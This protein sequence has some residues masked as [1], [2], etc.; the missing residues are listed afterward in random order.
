MDTFSFLLLILENLRLKLFAGFDYGIVLFTKGLARHQD[1]DNSWTPQTT[2]LR[3]GRKA[4]EVILPPRPVRHI[5]S[6]LILLVLPGRFFPTQWCW[7]NLCIPLL[8][9]PTSH[10]SRCWN[11]PTYLLNIANL[12]LFFYFLTFEK[13][14]MPYIHP[15][16]WSVGRSTSP[17]IFSIYRGI[18]ALY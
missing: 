17:L 1:C 12:C 4:F 16:G 11:P 7:Q 15:V 5:S 14:R 2:S 3:S 9:G 13:G 10:H 8:W 18:K 6:S